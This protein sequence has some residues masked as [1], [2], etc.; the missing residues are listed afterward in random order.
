VQQCKAKCDLPGCL[1]SWYT[2]PLGRLLEQA[3]RRELDDLLPGLF[4]YH[5]LQIGAACA[6]PLLGASPIRHRLVIDQDPAAPSCGLAASA[7]ALP[8]ASDSVDAVVLHHVLE[9]AADPHRALREVERILIPEGKV[10]IVSF[11]PFS[12]WGLRGWLRR[13]RGDAPWCGRF[14]SAPRVRDWL[15]LLGFDLL[16]SRHRLFRPPLQSPRLMRRLAFLEH[17]GYRWWQPLGGI[18]ILVARKRVVT[19]TPIRPRWAKARRLVGAGL[20]E[21]TS[22][23]GSR[24]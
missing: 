4:G 5:A 13:R 7:A 8:I 10:V 24:G 12:T 14:F 11:N 1:R 17:W 21:P 9:F 3:E 23:S 22:R 19:L 2:T 15:A 20:A 18:H 6:A 16:E